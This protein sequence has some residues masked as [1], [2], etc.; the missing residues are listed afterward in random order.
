MLRV[1]VCL[2]PFSAFSYFISL[3]GSSS[4]GRELFVFRHPLKLEP[5]GV[6]QVS[7][8][9]YHPVQYNDTADNI[10]LHYGGFHIDCDSAGV[11]LQYST[12]LTRGEFSPII[13]QFPGVYLDTSGIGNTMAFPDWAD[14]GLLHALMPTKQTYPE[15]AFV[16]QLN[17]VTYDRLTF[18]VTRNV[19]LSDSI[20]FGSHQVIRHHNRR[21]YWLVAMRSMQNNWYQ[22]LVWLVSGMQLSGPVSQ[23]PVYIH[24]YSNP[25]FQRMLQSPE[26]DKIVVNTG[27]GAFTLFK[28]NRSTGQ[29]YDRLPVDLQRI[30]YRPYAGDLVITTMNFS[31]YGDRLYAFTTDYRSLPYRNRMYQFDLTVWDSLAVTRRFYNYQT[32]D[33]I[34]QDF[35]P[36]SNNRVY[37]IQFEP[38]SDFGSLG[39]I[40]DPDSIWG[41]AGHELITV[42]NN[43][44]G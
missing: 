39:H 44:Y 42:S 26:E 16:Q 38:L 24:A 3:P 11:D 34:Y 5:N 17:L 31:P 22:P 30:F 21:D 40:L 6:N 10:H 12:I 1:K 7:Y 2:L 29:L 41:V 35:M 4:A 8:Y 32:Q 43:R 28:F 19:L 23:P 37:F 9:P 36:A 18:N 20:A 15:Y 13:N 25:I 33:T 27:K 14:P